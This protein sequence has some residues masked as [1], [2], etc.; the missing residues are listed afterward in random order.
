MSSHYRYGRRK[1]LQVGEF[2]ERRGFS[3]ARAQGS[4]GPVDLMAEK[5]RL[6]LAIQVKATRADTTSYT[7]LGPADETR[8]KR[9]AAARRAEPAL[10]LVCRDY[11]WLV[12]VRDERLIMEGDLKP[13]R[14]DY[15]ELS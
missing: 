2:L 3:P 8:L 5:G 4:R 7:R 11:L 9:S 13:L 1:E 12:S 14:R 6:R 10:A 15:P